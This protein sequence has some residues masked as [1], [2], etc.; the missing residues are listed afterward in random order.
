[1]V[2]SNDAKMP[3]R[4]Q[5]Q[6]PCWSTTVL[7]LSEQP[8]QMEVTTGIVTMTLA[9]ELADGRVSVLLLT[10][11]RAR[12]N[13]ETSRLSEVVVSP[14]GLCKGLQSLHHLRL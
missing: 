12:G 4:Q 2:A 13:R 6:A 10:C 8:W 1:M 5:C 11:F 9:H 3:W 7:N 14:V